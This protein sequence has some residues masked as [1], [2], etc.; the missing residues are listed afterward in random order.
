MSFSS[1]SCCFFKHTDDDGHI[2][3]YGSDYDWDADDALFI[4][5][6]LP[7]S[8]TSRVG[9]HATGAT[10]PL[11]ATPDKNLLARQYAH[12]PLPKWHRKTFPHEENMTLAETAEQAGPVEVLS[13]NSK[14]PPVPISHPEP[15]P[16]RV[17]KLPPIPVLPIHAPSPPAPLSLPRP[18]PTPTRDNVPAAPLPAAP[19]PVPTPEI[20]SPLSK[21]SL[22]SARKVFGVND[23]TPFTTTQA[24]HTPTSSGATLARVI[25]GTLYLEGHPDLPRYVYDPAVFTPEVRA[26]IIENISKPTGKKG[27]SCRHIE[28]MDPTTNVIGSFCRTTTTKKK[29]LLSMCHGCDTKGGAPGTFFGLFSNA[30]LCRSCCSSK[31]KEKLKDSAKLLGLRQRV[32][33]FGLGVLGKTDEISAFCPEV[34]TDVFYC[35]GMLGTPIPSTDTTTGELPN[36]CYRGAA[37]VQSKNFNVKSKRFDGGSACCKACHNKRNNKRDK[38]STRGRPSTK[39]R[40]TASPS[41]SPSRSPSPTVAPIR[42]PA[43]TPPASAA[44]VTSISVPSLP[45]LPV[46]PSAAMVAS[47]STPFGPSNTAV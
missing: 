8:P 44:M 23:V 32:A 35:A 38:S 30:A 45:S 2:A 7:S 46:A 5:L 42:S 21:N 15:T 18:K 25:G 13:P 41:R 19:L 4:G 47:I 31:D 24:R 20:I 12:R 40:R 39:L 43:P 1:P 11:L 9:S 14:T 3:L 26:S 10:H 28:V 22:A 33:W 37:T 16:T 34:E 29:P 27:S 17:E 6:G 36:G